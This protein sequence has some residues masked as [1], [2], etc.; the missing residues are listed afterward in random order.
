MSTPL[1]LEVIVAS[2]RAGRFAP[3]VA[4]WFLRVARANEG[5]E[6][7]VIDL[8]DTSLPVDLSVTDEVR[9]YLERIDAADAFVVVTSEYNHG[10]PAA[11]KTALDTGKR[12]WRGKPI[13]FVSYGGLS[14]GLRAVEQL[15]QVVA[16]VHMVSIRETVSFHEAKRKFDAEGETWDGAAIDAAQRLLRQLDWWGRTLRAAGEPYPG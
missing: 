11:L 14:G 1:R 8:I 6:V 10:Y 12:E 13:G 16:E 4:D 2:V 9:A 7:G 5:F 15:R 3:V